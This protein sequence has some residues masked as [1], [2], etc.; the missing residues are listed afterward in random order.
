MHSF[1][2]KFSA[3]Q[4]VKTGSHKKNVFKSTYLLVR[5][6]N[7][8]WVLW[9]IVLVLN[10]KYPV[11]LTDRTDLYSGKDTKTK[12]IFSIPWDSCLKRK[13]KSLEFGARE[14]YSNWNWIATFSAKQRCNNTVNRLSWLIE[15]SW[16]NNV[17]HHAWQYYSEL[18]KYK[19]LFTLVEC[20]S[21]GKHACIDRTT[22]F[23]I[24]IYS[25]AE[26][27]NR[28]VKLSSETLQPFSYQDLDGRE[29][30]TM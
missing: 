19:R 4:S 28:S 10:S 29:K 14:M 16:T 24:T 15:Q 7:A 3:F 9:G 2:A 5:L 17:V 20:W 22:T 1:K 8:Y 12:I 6:G 26:T 13:T 23:T 30:A 18:I 25:I 21:R 27:Q 11:S